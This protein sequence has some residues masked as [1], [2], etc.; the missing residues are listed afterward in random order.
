[1]RRGYSRD[2]YLG[3]TSRVRELLPHASISSDFMSGFC[4]ESEE[5]HAQT[6]SL[7]ETVRF[8]KVRNGEYGVEWGVTARNCAL[9]R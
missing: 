2:T 7:M 5:D 3:L 1:M 8:E 6:I 4:G 9:R